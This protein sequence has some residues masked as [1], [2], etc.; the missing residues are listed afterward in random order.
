MVPPLRR[1]DVDCGESGNE[2]VAVQGAHK[3]RPYSAAYTY[4][5][6]EGAGGEVQVADFPLAL[7]WRA[8]STYTARRVHTVR[9]CSG[10]TWEQ[11]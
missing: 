7:D 8:W 1:G 11:S 3:G 4:L 10:R 5:S 2:G 9:R 6:Q